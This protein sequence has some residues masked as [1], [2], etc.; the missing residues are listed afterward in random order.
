M[1]FSF[2]DRLKVAIFG[3]SHAEA[4]GVTV[5]GIPA[6]TR[7]DLERLQAFLRRRAPGRAL[8]TP[9]AEADAPVFLSGVTDGRT[10]GAPLA[11]VIYNTNTRSKDYSELRVKPRP[12]HS[13]YPAAVKFGGANDIAGGGQFSARL[14]APLC[15]VGGIVLDIL[16]KKGIEIAAHLKS[17]GAVDDSP[18]DPLRADSALFE[19]LQQADLPTVDPTAAERMRAAIEEA[20]AAGDSVGGTVECMIAGLPVGVGDGGYGG[21]DGAIASVVFGIPAVKGIEFGAGFSAARMRG[22][23]NNDAFFFENGVV[24]TKTNHC[25]GIL[26][27]MSDGMPVLFTAAFKPTPSIAQPQ[28]TVD[29][30]KKENTTLLVHGRHDP[31][32]AVR[33]VPV[34]EAAAAVAVYDCLLAAGQG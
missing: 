14:T 21:L 25:G 1:A 15:I 5:E 32:V 3:Q 10:N 4:I 6:G 23:Q 24:K 34:V 16:R 28:E 20:R 2:G 27:G 19:R 11:V 7:I 12:G 8:T 9:R 18:F 17:V 29:L 30:E 13:D 22:S 31:C 26:G 33:A